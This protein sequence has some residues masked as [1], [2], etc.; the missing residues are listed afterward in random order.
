MSTRINL[1]IDRRE[2]HN[3]DRFL[4]FFRTLSVLPLFLVLVS[5]ISLLLLSLNAPIAD[6]QAQR[7][8]LRRQQAGFS[9]KQAE[10]L[11]LSN[12]LTEAKKVV[13]TRV[14]YQQL[15][16]QVRK[17]FLGSIVIT[18]LS[19]DGAKTLISGSSPSLVDINA[20]LLNMENF[21][22]EEKRFSDLT[23]D[24]LS[25]DVKKGV[26]VFAMSSSKK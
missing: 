19:I 10:Y 22:K 25:L 3:A 6:L 18:S 26:Y 5:S 4:K 7:E 24:Q 11:L 14:D 17:Q 13:N 9:D 2:K 20:S 16:S 15:I 8:T 21:S 12:R 23:L 1:L